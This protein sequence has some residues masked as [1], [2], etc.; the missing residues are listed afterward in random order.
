MY[1]WVEQQN[2]FAKQT[3]TSAIARLMNKASKVLEGHDVSCPS[4]SLRANVEPLAL[5]KKRLDPTPCLRLK[6]EAQRQ[7]RLPRITHANTQ[8]AIKIKKGRRYQRVNVISII[9]GV[10]HLKG[11]DQ[12]IMFS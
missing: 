5:F 1:A 3:L 6:L 11:W 2:R 10:K 4:G 9:K 7:L 8:K 12:P